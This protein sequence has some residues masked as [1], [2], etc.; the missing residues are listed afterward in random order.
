MKLFNVGVILILVLVGVC[1]Y[2]YLNPKHAP[3]FVQGFIP[4]AQ[5]S[6]SSSPMQNF[7]PPKF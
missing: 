1:A 3:S 2:W 5:I 6:G 7:R 4:A